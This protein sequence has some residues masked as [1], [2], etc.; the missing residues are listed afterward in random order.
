MRGLFF[1]WLLP[2]AWG[3][4][5]VGSFTGKANVAEPLGGAIRQQ[6]TGDE[7]GPAVLFLL[8]EGLNVELSAPPASC[9]PMFCHASRHA[10]NRPL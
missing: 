5:S 8:F 3:F 9:R 4:L 6:R 2:A 10:D 1:S 7:P